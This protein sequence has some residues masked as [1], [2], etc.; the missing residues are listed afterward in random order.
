MTVLKCLDKK[1]RLKFLIFFG[2]STYFVFLYRKVWFLF[3]KIKF[4]QNDILNLPKP[5]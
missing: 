3:L 2:Y 5:R 1:P 4:Q